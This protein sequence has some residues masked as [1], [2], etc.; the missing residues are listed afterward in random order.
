MMVDYRKNPPKSINGSP[1]V[2]IKDYKTQKEMDLQTKTEKAI[3][4]PKSNV[5][6]FLTADGSI[7]SVRP[8]GTEPKIKF[9]IGTKMELKQAVDYQKVNSQ[10]DE[11]IKGI[12]V[13]MKI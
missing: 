1:V 6:Q 11:K 12:C 8:S 13:D 9:Y 4:L 3:S 5:L 7:I 2:C 10:L